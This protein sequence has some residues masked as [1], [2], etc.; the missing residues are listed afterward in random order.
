M[1][2]ARA[3]FLHRLGRLTHFSLYSFYTYTWCVELS[4]LEIARRWLMRLLLVFTV[5]HLGVIAV[6][7]DARMGLA[8]ACDLL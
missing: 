8:V 5:F 3:R 6:D 2:H 4:L 7:R 1:A